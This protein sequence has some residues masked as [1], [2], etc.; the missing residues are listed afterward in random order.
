M[1]DN[2]VSFMS[3][4]I[5]TNNL[6][7]FLLLFIIFRLQ[8]TEGRVGRKGNSQFMVRTTKSL[9]SLPSLDCWAL[10]LSIFMYA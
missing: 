7:K 6:R 8:R 2:F 1:D 10:S 4:L 9:I 5:Y 3:Y